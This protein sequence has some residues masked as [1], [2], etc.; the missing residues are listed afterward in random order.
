ML[1]NLRIKKK[2]YYLFAVRKNNIMYCGTYSRREMGE[3]I[4]STT[5]GEIFY[6]LY[7]F[8]FSVLKTKK[9]NELKDCVYYSE[10]RNKWRSVRHILRKAKA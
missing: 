8:I 6:S 9:I 5:T 2:G 4:T 10:Y 1:G 3:I 7:D